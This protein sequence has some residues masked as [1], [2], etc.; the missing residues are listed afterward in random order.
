MIRYRGGWQKLY[1]E[2]LR[3]NKYSDVKEM[4]EVLSKKMV[5]IL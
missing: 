1:I 4:L 5:R 3:R 2:D